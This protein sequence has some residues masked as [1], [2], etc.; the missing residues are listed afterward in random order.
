[1]DSR[2]LTQLGDYADGQY[3]H[4]TA[5]QATAIGA[6]LA[7]LAAGFAEPA[8]DGVW[9]LRAGGHHTH[10]RL[11]A[12]RLRLDPTI[13]APLRALPGSGEVSRFPALRWEDAAVRRARW[14]RESCW[15]GGISD[16]TRLARGVADGSGRGIWGS[17]PVG[18]V[19]VDA[20]ELV[21]GRSERRWVLVRVGPCQDDRCSH[22]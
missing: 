4:V 2:T 21:H 16:A 15:C 11:Y 22:R 17:G 7:E 8:I 9:P 6:A 20:A 19:V 12:A 3:G 5:E 18:R 13:S 14:A 1:V 10:P